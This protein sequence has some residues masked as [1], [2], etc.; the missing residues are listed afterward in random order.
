MVR[1][2]DKQGFEGA[3]R[4]S[5]RPAVV[6]FTVAWCPHCKRLRPVIEEIAAEHAGVI[7]VYYVDTDEQQALAERYD[8]MTVPTVLVFQNGGV[9]GSAVNPRTKEALLDLI[10]KT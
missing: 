2:L 7:D 10:F 6:D 5:V 4:D 3:L 9:V 8:I 1:N